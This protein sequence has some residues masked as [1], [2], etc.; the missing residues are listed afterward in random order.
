MGL[1]RSND[2]EDSYGSPGGGEGG[3]GGGDGGE[4]NL[5]VQRIELSA[6]SSSAAGAETKGADGQATGGGVGGGWSL[7]PGESTTAVL[8]LRAPQGK[9][10]YV[11]CY[12]S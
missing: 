8:W 2:D 7:S 9:M 1:P 11:I 10:V 6:P 5:C 4:E 12:N 3:A